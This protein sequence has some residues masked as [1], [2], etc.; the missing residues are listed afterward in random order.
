MTKVPTVN[1]QSRAVRA[2]EVAAEIKRQMGD[3]LTSVI[4]RD[5]IRATR[6]R[7]YRLDAPVKKTAVE[8]MHTLLGVELKIGKRRLLCP[9]LAM[10][11]YLAVFARLGLAEVATPYDITQVPRLAD[12]LE[13]SWF[14]MLTLVERLAVEQ[15]ARFRNRV[16]AILIA[17][18][19]KDIIEAGAGPA[20]PQFNQNTKQRKAKL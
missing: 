10:A 14:R 11:R 7:S 2:E 6:T 17:D 20:I 19:R 4:Y 16:L 1:P 5:R 18:E 3:Q 12:D 15:S 13:S 9:D 8:I